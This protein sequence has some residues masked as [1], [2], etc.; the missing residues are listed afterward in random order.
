MTIEDV[1]WLLRYP[2]DELVMSRET[3]NQMQAAI[4]AANRDQHLLVSTKTMME[5]GRLESTPATLADRKLTLTGPTETPQ[6]TLRTR[7]RAT[8]KVEFAG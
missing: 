8:A 2:S 4:G 7:G 3:F 1:D 5:N 6:V